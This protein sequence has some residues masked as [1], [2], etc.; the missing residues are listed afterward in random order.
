MISYFGKV[1]SAKMILSESGQIA[2]EMWFEL[3]KHFP[4][5]SLYEFVVMPNHIHGIIII[6]PPN[7]VRTLNAGPLD[8][9]NKFMSYNV[10]TRNTM[11]LIFFVN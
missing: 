4:Y 8:A 2:Y 6:E 10:P 7:T 1:S 11:E 9:K 5:V 3:P